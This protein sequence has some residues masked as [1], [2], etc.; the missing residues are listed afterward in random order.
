VYTDV[1]QHGTP[2]GSTKMTTLASTARN[3]LAL[4]G[5]AFVEP[6][7]TSQK[8]TRFDVLLANRPTTIDP[9]PIAVPVP[10]VARNIEVKIASERQEWEEAF[11]LVASN[12]RARGYEVASSKPYRFTP[13]HALPD[14]VTFVAKRAGHVVA[15]FSIVP[16][17]TL[18]GMPMESLYGQEIAGLRQKSQRMAETISLADTGL[19]VREFLQVFVT[20]IKLAIQYHH[21][22]GG[23][24]YVIAVNPRHKAFYAKILGFETL[25]PCRSYSSVQDA[26]AEALWGNSAIVQAN[27]PRMYR[28]IFERPLPPQALLAPKMS[29]DLVRHFTDLSSQSGAGRVED[30]LA[31]RERYGSPRRW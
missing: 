11:Q 8:S 2:G 17:N 21:S 19:S 4:V 24:T 26:P 23:D 18:V 16:D 15:T 25:G 22:Q 13:Y 6:V 10:G 30:I 29:R 20:L 31:F 27:A 3:A 28:E 1:L 9:R 12:Y 5:P 14:T 7:P